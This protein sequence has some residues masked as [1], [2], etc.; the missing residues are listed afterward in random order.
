[1]PTTSFG[2]GVIPENTLAQRLARSA[3]GHGCGKYARVHHFQQVFIDQALVG[4]LDQDGRLALLLQ[5]RVNFLQVL[6]VGGQWVNEDFLSAEFVQRRQRAEVFPRHDDLFHVGLYR[7][8]E[9]D[10]L[11]A[12]GSNHQSVCDQITHAFRQRGLQL[13][14][15]DRNIRHLHVLFGMQLLIDEALEVLQRLV[16]N[17]LGL[18]VN[19]EKPR[20]AVEDERANAAALDHCI[21]VAGLALEV[22]RQSRRVGLRTRCVFC[23]RALLSE[24]QHGSGQ[25][26]RE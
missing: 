1:M 2:C 20:A 7:N 9:G 3:K 17:A 16:I 21:Q 6:V 11:F 22:Q 24:G 8:G 13:I 5:R 18:P 15:P 26:K 23:G 14:G 12:L 19:V 4:F 25:N 10:L